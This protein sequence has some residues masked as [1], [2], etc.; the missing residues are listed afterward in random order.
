M[1]TGK[2]IPYGLFRY[3]LGGIMLC[4]GVSKILQT[5]FIILPFHVW[6]QPLE[7]TWGSSLTW[8]FFSYSPWFGIL[9]GFCELIPA[10]LLFWRRT[11]L[12]GTLLMLPATAAVMIVNFAL[13]LWPSTQALSSG[14]FLLNLTLLLFEKHKLGHMLTVIMGKK[15]R[16]VK[17]LPETLV[18]IGIG[19]ILCLFISYPL[20]QYRKQQNILMG[21]WF[22]QHANEWRLIRQEINDSIVPHKDSRLYF[23]PYGQY[24][25][26]NDTLPFRPRVK[27]PRYLLDEAA[28][29]LSIYPEDSTGPVSV[30]TFSVPGDSLLVL[31]NGA[32]RQVY[33]KRV[34]NT[35]HHR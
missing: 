7:D 30:Y 29:S 14:L 13:H 26:V 19:G 16:L 24:L 17:T 35:R 9:L 23:M 27:A 1:N 20:L 25:L 3:L 15:E 28:G 31:E 11:A 12:L 33:R 34:M 32:Q 5:Q 21:N 2:A 22:G 8:A 6:Q 18:N 4:Y 10:L